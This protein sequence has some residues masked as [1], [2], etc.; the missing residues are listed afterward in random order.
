MKK[1]EQ[2]DTGNTAP[3]D[4][5]P[6]EPIGLLGAIKPLLQ[7]VGAPDLTGVDDI[8]SIDDAANQ[9]ERTAM[10][11]RVL[12]QIGAV[13]DRLS[14]RVAEVNIGQD[15]LAARLTRKQNSTEAQEMELRARAARVKKEGEIANLIRDEVRVLTNQM[16]MQLNSLKSVFSAEIRNHLRDLRGQ[17][18]VSFRCK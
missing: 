7:E 8:V 2:K 16:H 17:L 10:M 3:G 4:F 18:R 5:L 14:N 9:K 12:R 6:N 15:E 1:T 11:A 13:V